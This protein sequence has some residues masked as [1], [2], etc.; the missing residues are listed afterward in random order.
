MAQELETIHEI[1]VTPD[2]GERTRL[3][4]YKKKVKGKPDLYPA[5]PKVTCTR[6]D[7]LRVSGTL[8]VGVEDTGDGLILGADGRWFYYVIEDPS[9][10]DAAKLF[11]KQADVRIIRTGMV[12]TVKKGD[13][14]GKITKK[15]FSNHKQAVDTLYEINKAVIGANPDLIYPGQ[16]L[17]IPY[18]TH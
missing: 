4:S 3:Q 1:E 15:H 10:A 6:G 7:R 12:Y 9:N 2:S 13:T 18:N 17:F 8:K 16:K 5:E 14:L 11:V